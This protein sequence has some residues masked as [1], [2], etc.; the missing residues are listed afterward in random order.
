ML[1]SNQTESAAQWGNGYRQESPHIIDDAPPRAKRSAFFT[2]TLASIMWWLPLIWARFLY[3]PS[4][5]VTGVDSFIWALVTIVALVGIIPAVQLIRRV[6]QERFQD[7][8]GK[9]VGM[10]L[11]ALLIIAGI[12]LGW[13]TSS[14]P[15]GSAMGSIFYFYS[16]ALGFFFLV[17]AYVELIHALR[18]GSSWGAGYD[19][20][21]SWRV[22]NSAYLWLWN[23]LWFVIFYVIFFIV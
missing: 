3:A 8:T 23:V 22:E 14:L 9:L 20:G 16:A 2:I 1:G 21:S 4:Q 11:I 19:A 6:R 10:V 18:A 13:V 7:L 15:I 5:S 12:I 17:S